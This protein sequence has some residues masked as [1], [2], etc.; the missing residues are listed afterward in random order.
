MKLENLKTKFMAH[1]IIYFKTIDSTQNYAKKTTKEKLVDGTV[2]IADN[3]TSGI[4]THE[5]KWYTG[6]CENIAMTFVLYPECKISKLTEL[7][8]IIS[9]CIL[10][11]IKNLYGY[12]LEIKEPNDVIY[13][14]KKI[15]GILTESNCIGEIVKRLCI[16]IG[17]NVNQTDFPGNLK[18]IASSLKTEFNR[19]FKREEIISEFFNIFEKEYLKLIN[20]I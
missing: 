8:R 7:T 6:N 1:N 5:R 15:A 18:E 11:A 2:I 10:K 19:D 12:E 13:K 4:G 3:Q 14:N 16:G 9:E 17:L 20:D